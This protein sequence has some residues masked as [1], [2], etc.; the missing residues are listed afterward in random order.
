VQSIRRLKHVQILSTTTYT[1]WNRRRTSKYPLKSPAEL[2]SKLSCNSL[3]AVASPIHRPAHWAL[4]IVINKTFNPDKPSLIGSDWRV[5][6]FDSLTPTDDDLNN[7]LS[8]SQWLLQLK[9]DDK[10]EVVAVPTPKQLPNSN[11]CGLLA[12]HYLRVFLRTF[13]INVN[14][15]SSVSTFI[16]SNWV[17]IHTSFVS[18]EKYSISLSK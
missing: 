2:K 18:T 9:S 3:H 10:P 7:A 14:A 12:A 8:F 11:D 4:I 5:L 1:Y 13:A 6:Y 17:P 16:F 15:Y